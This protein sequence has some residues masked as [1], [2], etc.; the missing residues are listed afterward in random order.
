[1]TGRAEKHDKWYA[2]KSVSTIFR[3]GSEFDD[4]QC[5]IIMKKFPFLQ[6]AYFSE[7]EEQEY[8]T[9]IKQLIARVNK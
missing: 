8:K 2:H 9:R 3:E 1:M 5:K 4:E 6:K 7:N